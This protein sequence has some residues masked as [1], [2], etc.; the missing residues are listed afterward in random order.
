MADIDGRSTSWAFIVYPESLPANWLSILRDLH[1]TGAVSPLHDKD[2]DINSGEIKKSHYHVLLHFPSKKSIVQIYQI[3]RSLGSNVAP[4]TVHSFEGYFR[5]L[6]HADDPEK[7]QYNKEDI[8]PLCGLDVN[9]YFLPPK[10]EVAEIN[11]EIVKF[12]F[13]H[14][15]ICEF[16]VL[17][18][19]SFAHK[20]W[21]M[22]L[23]NY[24]CYGVNRILNSRRYRNE[25]KNK[26]N[27]K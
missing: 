13:D 11:Y 10:S 16:D 17:M 12:L 21:A 25:Q 7:Y 14:P 18:G 19:Q 26:E 22:I 15:E 20:N 5:Y 2:I 23:S 27:K 6:I 3:S 9:S 24:P 8:T 1:I 4:E